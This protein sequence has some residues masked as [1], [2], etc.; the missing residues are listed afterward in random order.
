[1]PADGLGELFHA[2]TEAL[3]WLGR[4]SRQQAGS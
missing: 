1:M 2:L 4:V 3:W